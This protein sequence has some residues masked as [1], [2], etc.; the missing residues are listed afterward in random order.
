MNAAK[1]LLTAGALATGLFAT[2]AAFANDKAACLDASLQAQALR[3]AHKL[4]E[5]REQLR[6]C[7]MSSCPAVVAADCATWL[8][9]VERTLPTVVLSARSSAGVDLVAVSVSVDGQPLVTKL[10]GQA[11][12][13]NAGAH[14]FH[15][16]GADGAGLDQQV[17]VREGEKNQAVSVVLGALPAPQAPAAGGDRSVDAAHPS[18]PWKTL[19]WVLGGAGVIGLGVGT[20]AGVIATSDKSSDC[21]NSTCKSGTL[22]GIKSVA[23][24]SD[25]GLIAGGV[26]LASGAALVLLAPSGNHEAAATVRISPSVTAS[27]GGIVLLGLW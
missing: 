25:V 3:A 23:L 22:G 16:V 8:S 15:F 18:S 7:A 27:G 4:V 9:E 14:T 24:V 21:A 2:T 5:A 6:V 26:L 12:S 10:D 20:V 13:M 11:L 19:G 1:W 17:V